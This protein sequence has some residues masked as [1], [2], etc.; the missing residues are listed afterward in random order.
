MQ[1]GDAGR[2]PGDHVELDAPF[3]PRRL[4]EGPG[5]DQLGPFGKLGREAKRDHGGGLDA[6]AAGFDGLPIRVLAE[7]G[8]VQPPARLD[9]LAFV[10]L[11]P[12]HILRAT[13]AK[14]SP[15]LEI[16]GREGWP[17][18]ILPFIEQ[19]AMFDQ[20][21]ADVATYMMY[22]TPSVRLTV[23]PVLVCPSDRLALSKGLGRRRLQELRDVQRRHDAPPPRR[24]GVFHYLS[25]TK[26]TG[27]TDGLSNTLFGGRSRPAASRD[28]LGRDG[29]LLGRQP[30]S[31]VYF[32]TKEQPNSTLADYNYTCRSTTF[33]FAPCVSTT[34][35]LTLGVNYARSYHS[36]GV[37]TA[38]GDAR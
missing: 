2:R 17:Q 24:R 25:K 28:R 20:Y 33:Q 23:I 34:G 38:M 5:R 19:N 21:K 31:G 3:A 12:G 29:L 30:S 22:V 4:F 9:R 1:P 36:G 8:C 32:S 37:N 35:D 14:A 27:V 18:H 16:H 11:D 13:T 26:A 6:E 10:D 15:A 7:R